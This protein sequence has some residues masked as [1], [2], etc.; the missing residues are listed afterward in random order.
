[1]TDWRDQALCAQVDPEIHFPEKGGSA[2]EARKVCFACEVR[3]ACLEWAIEHHER[4][5]I[6]G[7]KTETQRKRIELERERL[8]TEQGVA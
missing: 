3:A 1:M 7:G 5:G 8:R 6:W 4:F 2:R